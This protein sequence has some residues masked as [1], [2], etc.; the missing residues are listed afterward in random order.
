MVPVTERPIGVLV[1]DDEASVRSFAE[2]R[3]TNL[4]AR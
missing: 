1:V 3:L 4:T 2:L